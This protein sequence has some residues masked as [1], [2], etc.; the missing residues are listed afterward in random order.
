MLADTDNYDLQYVECQGL[1]CG[2]IARLAVTYLR[3]WGYIRQSS[4]SQDPHVFDDSRVRHN[5]FRLPE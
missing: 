3:E 1:P 4:S 5:A 2:E